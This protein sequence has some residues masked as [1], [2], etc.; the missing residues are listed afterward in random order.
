MLPKLLHN[1]IQKTRISRG[2]R[3]ACGGLRYSIHQQSFDERD[4]TSVRPATPTIP[5]YLLDYKLVIATIL[6][7]FCLLSRK[8]SDPDKQ[9]GDHFTGRLS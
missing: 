4:P 1:S 7:G 2:S 6:K 9:I 5:A 3:R 8:C